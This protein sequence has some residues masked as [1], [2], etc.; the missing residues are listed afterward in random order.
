MRRP[1]LGVILSSLIIILA[2]LVYLGDPTFPYRIP[3]ILALLFF[4][5]YGLF[6]YRKYHNRIV[7]S[8]ILFVFLVVIWALNFIQPLSPI[9]DVMIYR[10]ATGIATLMLLG[11][12]LFV[13]INWRKTSEAPK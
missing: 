11:L 8:I 9:V 3:L 5:V 1:G 10:L 12:S 6:E 2:N 4:I 13:L 7:Y